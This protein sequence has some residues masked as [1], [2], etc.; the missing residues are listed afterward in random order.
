ML[1]LQRSETKQTKLHMKEPDA[2][3]G[4]PQHARNFLMECE[5]YIQGNPHQFPSDPNKILFVLSYCKEGTALSFREHIVNQARNSGGDYGSWEAFTKTFKTAFVTTDDKA[6]AIRELRQLKQSGDLDAYIQKFKML[7][8]RAHITDFETQKGYFI[9]G[10]SKFWTDR[11]GWQTSL[12]GDDIEEWYQTVQKLD[13]NH[14]FINSVK[15]GNTG[16]TYTKT[17]LPAGEPMDVDVGKLSQEER[18]RHFVEKRCFTCHKVGHM[19]RDCFSKPKGGAQRSRYNGKDR[20]G[21]AGRGGK[22]AQIRALMKDI[23]PDERQQLM[24]EFR[25]NPLVRIRALMQ[26]LPEEEKEQLAEEVVSEA[27]PEEPQENFP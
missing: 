20:Q 19:A 7:L 23:S 17:S 11:L 16:G 9:G 15:G 6:E 5:L 2:Y 24:K 4:K 1:H 18:E 25:G 3:D 22:V 10:L 26:E 14:R 13:Q 27:S 8:T 21:D 12:P